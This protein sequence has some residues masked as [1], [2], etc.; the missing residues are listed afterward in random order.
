[1][2]IFLDENMNKKMLRSLQS[3]YPRHRFI[4][5][6]VDT[7]SGM[8]DIPLFAEVAR[9]GGEVFVTNDI[10]QLAERP[11]E[12]RACCIA[13]LH[14]LGI[15]RVTAKGRLALYGE[16]SYLFGMLEHVVRDIEA[17]AASGPRY[18]QML[19]GHAA[20]PGDVDDSGLL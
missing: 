1:M 4:V 9:V 6:G 13:G 12:R 2:N 5:G 14:W 20:L 19:R 3:L 7:P 16:C 18:Y 8:L 15:P 10:K 11:A 17:N